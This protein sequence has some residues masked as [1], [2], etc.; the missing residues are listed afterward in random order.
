MILIVFYANGLFYL[1]MCNLFYVENIEKAVKNL[2]KETLTPQ[3]FS[4]KG[5]LI[6]VTIIKSFFL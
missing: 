3:R 5:E 1:F 2:Q 6:E 4:L